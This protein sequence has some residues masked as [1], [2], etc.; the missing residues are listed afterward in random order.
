MKK[1]TVGELLVGFS[2]FSLLIMLINTFIILIL[3]EIST[4][5]GYEISSLFESI[6]QITDQCE[7][8]N[9]TRGP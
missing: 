6:I 8:K 4:K 5:T 7:S 1:T 9:L 2:L 3:I